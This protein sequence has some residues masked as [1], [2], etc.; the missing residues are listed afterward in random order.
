MCSAP[1]IQKS[2]SAATAAGPFPFG[3]DCDY[4][5]PGM[6]ENG[7]D[8]HLRYHP[9]LPNRSS[10]FFRRVIHPLRCHTALNALTDCHIRPLTRAAPPDI[11]GLPTYAGL[12]ACLRSNW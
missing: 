4:A 2:R 1:P 5:H 12:E 6:V 8:V 11:L 9:D 10:N 3:R 7:R